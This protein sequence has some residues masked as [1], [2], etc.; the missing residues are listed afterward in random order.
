MNIQHYED[1]LAQLK[2]SLEIDRNILHDERK[3]G[4]MATALNNIGLCLK[5]MLQHDNRFYFNYHVSFRF[6]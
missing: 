2:Q 1:V 5:K 3:D 6:C 4:N